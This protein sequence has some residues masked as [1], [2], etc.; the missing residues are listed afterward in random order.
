MKFGSVCSGIE[1]ASV[2]WEPLGWRAEWF[3]ETDKF[4]KALLKHHY[5]DTPNFGDMRK[6]LKGPLDGTGPIELLVGGTLCQAFSIAGLRGGMGDDRGNLALHFLRIA[7]E[8]QPRWVVWENV[9]GVR[10]SK[11]HRAPDPVPPR[12]DLDGSDGPEVGEKRVETDAY[13]AVERHSFG[14]FLAGLQEC[15]YG[16]AYRSLD[17]QFLRI[18]SHPRAVPQRR[19]R[20]FVIGYLGDWRPPAA[21]LFERE[22]MSWSRPPR[23]KKTE[24]IAGTLT[25]RLGK[26]RGI[27]QD[28][29]HLVAGTLKANSG[30]GGWSNSADHAAANLMVT[31]PVAA[32]GGGNTDGPVDIATPCLSHHA[33]VDLETETFVAQPIAPPL[34]T[35][36]YGDHESRDGLLVP[37]AFN[38]YASADNSMNPSEV[39]PT[40]DVG[41]AGGVVAVSFRGRD[42]DTLPEIEPVGVSP[43]LRASEGGSNKQHVL[44]EERIRR[45]TPLEWERLMGFEDH[46]TT[47]PNLSLIHI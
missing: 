25:G 16:F 12:I 1:A 23:R 33:R 45:L 26:S 2:A 20:V 15:G 21:V 10:S 30:G 19:K 42:G 39:S 14:C 7:R 4:C 9:P 18:Q 5:P 38:A 17:A 43:A 31:I 40:L 32:Y 6:L 47:Y 35:R 22:G 3:S 27:G 44:E 36:Q 28:T 46:Y 8:T 37:Y 29:A 41:K 24:E 34:T 11:F 13:E